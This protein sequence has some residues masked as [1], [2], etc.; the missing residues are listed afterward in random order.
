[1][2]TNQFTNE[3]TYSTCNRIPLISKYVS[4]HPIY[5]ESI[6]LYPFISK[7]TWLT[8]LTLTTTYQTITIDE[9][10]A[11]MQKD[12]EIQSIVDLV[13]FAIDENILRLRKIKNTYKVC[14]N[15]PLTQ[16]LTEQLQIQGNVLPH[17]VPPLPLTKKCKGFY[18]EDL[19]KQMSHVSR[20]KYFKPKDINLEFL[21]LY[22]SIPYTFEKGFFYET[23]LPIEIEDIGLAK[24]INEVL[25]DLPED[26]WLTN[27]YDKRGR[28]Y[29]R[30]YFINPQG[31]DWQKAAITLKGE[32]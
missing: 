12:F 29:S 30:A 10:I 6:N 24:A 2:L 17:V 21:D 9:I 25:P 4:S 19:N 31:T 5:L 11:S 1:M 8:L 18:E 20:E 15:I 7:S 14:S 23:D 3:L 26:I 28:I 13:E 22:N 27:H 32:E 16:E